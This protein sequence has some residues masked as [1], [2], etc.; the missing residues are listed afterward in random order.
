MAMNTNT[1]SL[2]QEKDVFFMHLKIAAIRSRIL[3][4]E[5]IE[6]CLTAI[7]FSNDFIESIYITDSNG[8]LVAPVI[9]SPFIGSNDFYCSPAA[10]NFNTTF[11]NYILKLK[12]G[13]AGY[14]IEG[15]FVSPYSEETCY[16]IST[17]LNNSKTLYINVINLSAYTF[18]GK[19]AV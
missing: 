3:T 4:T 12:A 13:I 7:T 15:P 5:D 8:S 14:S 10:V 11:E 6:N 18:R 17:N 16:T 9:I 1:Q 19:A 2:K